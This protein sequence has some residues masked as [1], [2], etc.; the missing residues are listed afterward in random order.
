[1][2][3]R[4]ITLAEEYLLQY[5]MD[6]KYTCQT[7]YGKDDPNEVVYN[8]NDTEDD[9]DADGP[10]EHS[11]I[12]EL[13]DDLHQGVCSNVRMNTAASESNSDHKHNI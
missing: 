2:V 9:N 4:H 13:L 5:G 6:K 11:G 12:G 1:M 10:I 3:Y 8:D 7:W